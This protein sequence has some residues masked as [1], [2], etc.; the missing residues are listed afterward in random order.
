MTEKK[1][2]VEDLL[3]LVKRLRDPDTGCGWDKKQTFNSLLP[4]TLEECYELID[5]VESGDH[6]HICEELGDYLFQAIFYARLAEEEQWFDFYEVINT[7]VKKILS[8]HPHVFPDGTLASAVDQSL[9]S[10]QSLASWKK[11][12][13]H[14]RNKN[15]YT[16]CLDDIPVSLPA[17]LRAIKLLNR[18]SEYK[19]NYANSQ[20][21]I[22]TLKQMLDKLQS[23][24]AVNDEI[25]KNEAEQSIG[26]ILFQCV[27]LA[28]TL[29]IDCETSLR[30]ANR[31]FQR[32]FTMLEKQLTQEN[33]PLEKADDNLL[34]KIWASNSTSN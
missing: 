4:C 5:A 24:T 27:N 13:Q 17:F 8:R 14:E 22:A 16:S 18:V 11:A 7:L 26:D 34:A 30:K 19:F 33:I 20:Q 32:K 21:S 10:E 25:D 12:K 9:S 2:S 6:K 15:G 23:L 28:R 31:E 29:N 1:Y 3:Y